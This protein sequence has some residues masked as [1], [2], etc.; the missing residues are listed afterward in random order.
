MFQYNVY[1]G[2]HFSI[3]FLRPGYIKVSFHI[4][5][6]SQTSKPVNVYLLKTLEN[7]RI[8]SSPPPP[9]PKTIRN[10]TGYKILLL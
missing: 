10:N 5:T 6:E 9:P 2:L 7:T 4:F 8:S 1:F 3:I